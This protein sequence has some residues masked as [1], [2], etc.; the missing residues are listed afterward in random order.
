[1]Q[2]AYQRYEQVSYYAFSWELTYRGYGR[3]VT[4]KS[5]KIAK[6]E[7]GCNYVKQKYNPIHQAGDF[8]INNLMLLSEDTNTSFRQISNT[9]QDS[10]WKIWQTSL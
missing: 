6:K 4:E 1:M 9:I 10:S 3:A 2:F 5:M 7:G 8:F